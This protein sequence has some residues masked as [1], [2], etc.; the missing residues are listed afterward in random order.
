MMSFTDRHMFMLNPLESIELFLLFFSPSSL[1]F[2]FHLPL[3]I[4]LPSLASVL[5]KAIIELCIHFKIIYNELF[6]NY[7]LP[8][9]N[10]VSFELFL[11]YCWRYYWCQHMSFSFSLICCEGKLLLN[12]TTFIHN[13]TQLLDMVSFLDLIKMCFIGVQILSSLFFVYLLLCFLDIIVI[14]VATLVYRMLI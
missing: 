2:S 3:F 6:K 4:T 10:N 8:L 11:C 13:I 14:L 9:P 5:E 1:S 7:D 12:S